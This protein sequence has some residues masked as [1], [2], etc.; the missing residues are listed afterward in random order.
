VACRAGAVGGGIYVL[1]TGVRETEFK[2]PSGISVELTNKETVKTKFLVKS[3]ES[4]S[5]REVPAASNVS[6][7]M[8]VVS[9]DLASLFVSTVEGGPTAAVSVVVFPSSS[10]LVGREPQAYPVYIMVHS[11]DTG[12]CPGGQSKSHDALVFCSCIM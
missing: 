2:V 10:L 5:E 6:K 1:G 11:S 12:E 8:S 9:S 3:G 4:V 7:M